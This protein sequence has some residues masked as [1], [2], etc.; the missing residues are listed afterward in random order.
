[1]DG[2]DC[3]KATPPDT[4]TGS[5]DENPCEHLT[6]LSTRSSVACD[7]QN[8]A[9]LFRRVASFLVLLWLDS[10]VRRHEEGAQ[11]GRCVWR[12]YNNLNDVGDWN[13]SRDRPL[14]VDASDIATAHWTRTGAQM[15]GAH[16]GVFLG[17]RAAHFNIA[18]GADSP[19]PHFLF[20]LFYFSAMTRYETD[21]LAVVLGRGISLPEPA[22][23]AI[24]PEADFGGRSF[25]ANCFL[26]P[27]RGSNVSRLHARDDLGER[28]RRRCRGFAPFLRGP[29]PQGQR[30]VGPRLRQEPTHPDIRFQSNK[31]IIAR[32][33]KAAVTS[34]VDFGAGPGPHASASVSKDARLLATRGDS[35]LR[36][37]RSRL[38]RPVRCREH[39]RPRHVALYNRAL[40]ISTLLDADSILMPGAVRLVLLPGCRGASESSGQLDAARLA[41]SPRDL[42]QCCTGVRSTANPLAAFALEGNISAFTEGQRIADYSARHSR[43]VNE[44][45][46]ISS[47]T[48]AVTVARRTF[49]TTSGRRTAQD[50]S[51]WRWQDNGRDLRRWSI[52]GCRSK[53]RRKQT[54]F[55]HDA[56]ASAPFLG[57]AK[58]RA[59]RFTCGHASSKPP[60]ATPVGELDS[61]HARYERRVMTPPDFR[62]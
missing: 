25:D 17:R 42:R 38:C 35:R 1:V 55:S 62:M 19:F 12:S 33:S 45:K 57:I 27:T 40:P 5:Q 13:L 47:R 53:T 43:C 7:D 34:A 22:D 32:S 2:S 6:T 26:T 29:H 36:R 31:A 11:P 15:H 23:V 60:G 21:D 41:F 52:A 58:L 24:L 39:R 8:G 14:V 49:T 51:R 28:C 4:V 48:L 44:T 20:C 37:R 18:Y 61:F 10:D 16:M 56:S 59:A 50:S 46:T 3:L 9:L 54:Q 30:H